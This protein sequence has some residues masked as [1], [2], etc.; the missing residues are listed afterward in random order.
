MSYFPE[1]YTNK[2][3]KVEVEL[4]FSHYSTKSD[5]KNRGR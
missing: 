5:S 1:L 4:D 3:E 2:K